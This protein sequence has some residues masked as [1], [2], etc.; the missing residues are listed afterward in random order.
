MAQSVIGLLLFLFLLAPLSLD[1]VG[2]LPFFFFLPFV[3][4]FFFPVPDFFGSA[5]LHGFEAPV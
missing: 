2:L 1:R 3:L 5:A 4:F